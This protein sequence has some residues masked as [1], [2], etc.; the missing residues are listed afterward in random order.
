MRLLK[1]CGY[2]LVEAHDLPDTFP[3]YAILSHTWISPKD[4]ITYQDMKNRKE[5]IEN[6]IYKQKGWSKLRAYCDRAA[7]DGWEWA[8][9]D[10]CCIDKTNPADT[11]E[12][13]NAMFRWY[14]NAGICYAYLEDVNFL[15]AFSLSDLGSDEEPDEVAGS[16]NVACFGNAAHAAIKPIFTRAKW[17]SR[18]WTLQELL[19]PNYLVF[20]DQ[21]W[22]RIG[23]R[24]DWAAEI[25]ES[26]RIEARHLTGFNPRDF[27]SC[28]IAMRLSWASRRKTTVEED[29]TYSLV[30]LF[31]I[32]LPL[33]YGE[34]RLRAFNRLQRELITVYNDDSIFA[35]RAEPCIETR[36]LSSTRKGKLPAPPF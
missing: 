29:E 8:W 1:T 24:E 28:S 20:V 2:G 35:W 12:A 11:Q 16:E 27:R 7:K 18:G 13:I 4:E 33:I 34:G 19:A 3:Q 26:S 31:A 5:D 23:C 9:M 21:E 25:R 6:D 30:G 32:S 14:Q 36:P 15:K 17:F 22:R 10:T